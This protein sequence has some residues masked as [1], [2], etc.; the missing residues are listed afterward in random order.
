MRARAEG[1]FK[2]AFVLLISMTSYNICHIK[3][4]AETMDL[5]KMSHSTPSQ[6]CLKCARLQITRNTAHDTESLKGSPTMHRTPTQF[7]DP[8]LFD[9]EQLLKELDRCREMVLLILAPTHGT[10]FAINNAIS[11]IWNLTQNLRFLLQLHKE[12]QRSFAKKAVKLITAPTKAPVSS[13]GNR[14]TLP[15][16]NHPVAIATDLAPV[17]MKQKR[18]YF[19]SK[20]RA[21]RKM[22]MSNLYLP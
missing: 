16:N 15:G 8:W 5:Q 22:G 9:S 7:P 21:G 13:M 3:L 14:D 17:C 12:G 6:T 11:A 2:D 20:S 10:H 1:N 4:Q 18:F 19:Q